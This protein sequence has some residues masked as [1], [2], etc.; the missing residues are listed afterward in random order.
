MF[1]AEWNTCKCRNV[2]FSTK[3]K[4]SD[5]IQK[6]KRIL[7]DRCCAWS[8]TMLHKVGEL[9]TG[10]ISKIVEKSQ[11]TKVEKSTPHVCSRNKDENC[12]VPHFLYL[13]YEQNVAMLNG[14]CNVKLFHE[15]VR[16]WI[17]CYMLCYK[18]T[19]N[20][21]NQK[22]TFLLYLFVCISIL[23][24]CWNMHFQSNILLSKQ[25]LTHRFSIQLEYF[26]FEKY[27]DPDAQCHF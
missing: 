21:C 10:N 18:E 19:I 6:N 17:L 4:I 22:G 2:T 5:T 13:F 20:A 26:F 23:W 14:I 3:W 7:R 8:E 12:F 16:I 9:Q 11:L 25:L 24:I 1:E 27:Q 15:A